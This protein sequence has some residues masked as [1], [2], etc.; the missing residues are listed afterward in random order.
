MNYAT[1][2]GTGFF[3]WLFTLHGILS[4]IILA[5]MIYLIFRFVQSQKNNKNN[6]QSNQQPNQSSSGQNYTSSSDTDLTSEK[7]FWDDI[8]IN[9]SLPQRE[10]EPVPPN[11]IP[12]T[13]VMP[14]QSEKI[15]AF[16]VSREDRSDDNLW[17]KDCTKMLDES[18]NQNENIVSLNKDEKGE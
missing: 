17:E 1:S 18:E 13:Y 16:A 7:S 4:V 6:N 2:G 14:Q 10:E 8:N 3:N 11:A 5:G 12:P 9:Q 15:S